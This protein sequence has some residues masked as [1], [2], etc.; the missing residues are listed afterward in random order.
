MEPKH[1]LEYELT[2]ERANDI[3]R[4]LLR[5]S[6]W[7]GWRRDVPLLVGWLVFALMLALPVL[8]G[9]MWPG[10]AGA[11]LFFATFFVLCTVVGRRWRSYAS[12]TSAL[13]ALH[14]PDRRVRLEFHEGRVSMETEFIRGEGAWTELEEIVV[15][16]SFWALR[17]SNGGQIVIPSSLVT[18]ELQTFLHGKAEQALAEIVRR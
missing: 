16:P 17:F 1:V 10:V 5:F 15:F 11:M 9:W 3:Q 6:M 7:R 8:G 12:V 18:P 14:M 2:S 13:V 4:T